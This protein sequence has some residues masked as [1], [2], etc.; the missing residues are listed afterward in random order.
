[1]ALDQPLLV[2]P[3]LELAEGL[4]QLRDGHGI[5]TSR[6]PATRVPRPFKWA[7]MGNIVK[8][9]WSSLSLGLILAAQ[10]LDHLIARLLAYAYPVPA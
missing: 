9:A 8:V 6:P 7:I 5:E 4:D 3:S 2:V 1:V 10:G